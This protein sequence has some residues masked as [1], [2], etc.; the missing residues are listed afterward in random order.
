[1]HVG[2]VSGQKATEKVGRAMTKGVGRGLDPG[3][4]RPKSPGQ[5]GSRVVL[6]EDQRTC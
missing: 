4:A 5:E 1:M 2:I 3:G 6:G